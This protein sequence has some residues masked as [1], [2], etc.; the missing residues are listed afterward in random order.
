MIR[1][2]AHS[3]IGSLLS[4]TQACAK[5]MISK[6]IY[7]WNENYP[8]KSTFET[9]INRGELFVLEYE[10]ELVGCIVISTFMDAVYMP[11]KWLTENTN[12][13]YIHRLA[14]D[15]KHQGN[16]HAQHLMDFAENY[17]ITNT[18]TSI[19]LDTFSKNTRNQKFY[20][21]RDYKRLGSIYF[22]QKSKHPFYCYERVL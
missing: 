1:K 8:D 17:A 13:I 6:G 20:A 11:V 2:A 12:N 18:Y 7:Q 9:D 16:G 10:K 3:D 14:I 4:I 5:H 21:R 19:R 22:P 15:P